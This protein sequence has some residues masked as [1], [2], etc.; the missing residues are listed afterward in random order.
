MMW[1]GHMCMQS[2]ISTTFWL[3]CSAS[4]TALKGAVWETSN[5]GEGKLA[6]SIYYVWQPLCCKIIGLYCVRALMNHA[7]FHIGVQS[8][9]NHCRRTHTEQV[10]QS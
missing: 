2:S 4:I 9:E 10:L 5:F 7:K 8:D 6:R 1:K 3:A